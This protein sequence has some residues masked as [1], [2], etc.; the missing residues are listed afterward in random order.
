MRREEWKKYE[1]KGKERKT[2]SKECLKSGG[3]GVR[4]WMKECTRHGWKGD[5]LQ[6]KGGTMRTR[7]K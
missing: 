3:D 1:R 5:A 7:W 2:T 6:T 4:W